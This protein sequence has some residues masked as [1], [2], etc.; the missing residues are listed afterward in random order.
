MTLQEHGV[1][2]AGLPR[3]EALLTGGPHLDPVVLVCLADD[4]LGSDAETIVPG[5]AEGV[6]QVVSRAG[7]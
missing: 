7:H 3:C 2:V 6:G 5:V 1:E 4:I